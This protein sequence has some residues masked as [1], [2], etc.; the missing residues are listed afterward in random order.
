MKRIIFTFNII[1]V[2]SIG[3]S[4]NNPIN[5][6]ESYELEC[7][8]CPKLNTRTYF[9]LPR[10]RNRKKIG[11]GENVRIE[12]RNAGKNGNRCG[13]LSWSAT[14]VGVLSKTADSTVYKMTANMQPGIIIITVDAID[15]TCTKCDFPLTL[16]FEVIEPESVYWEYWA[17]S[18]CPAEH[19]E[20]RV[21]AKMWLRSYLLP[22]D[23]N[24]GNVYIGEG[25]VSEPGTGYFNGLQM[26]HAMN[27]PFKVSTLSSPPVVVSGKGTLVEGFDRVGGHFFCRSP[28]TAPPNGRDASQYGLVSLQYD[29]F[30]YRTMNPDLT[31]NFDAVYQNFENAGGTNSTFTISKESIDNMSR[32]EKS[33]NLMDSTTTCT[34]D[35]GTPPP[36]ACP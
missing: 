32:A 21:G 33:Y 31:I 29:Q 36:P 9:S 14:G 1:F 12:V 22:D 30:Y 3:F 35:P 28:E 2:L 25:A 8:F 4:Q 26:T 11:I 7:L 16:E 6:T 18:S 10:P 24:F 15:N 34:F 27:G 20:N 5:E 13:E 19:V 23:V 17:A